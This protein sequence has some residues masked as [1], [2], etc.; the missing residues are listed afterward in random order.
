MTLYLNKKN[1]FSI[2]YRYWFLSIILLLLTTYTFLFTL[3]KA[4]YSLQGLWITTFAD[5]LLLYFYSVRINFIYLAI[6]KNKNIKKTVY[7][8]FSIYI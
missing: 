3:S 6:N 5:Y 8:V 7:L 2:S 1:V 4:E